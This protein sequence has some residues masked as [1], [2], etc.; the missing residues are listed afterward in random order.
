M[1]EFL[2]PKITQNPLKRYPFSLITTANG[3]AFVS[4]QGPLDLETGKV[5]GGDIKAQ[6]KL[7]LENIRKV[8][9]GAGLTMNHLVK[10]TVYITDINDFDAMSQAY[11]EHFPDHLPSRTTVGVATLWGGIKV[12]IEA[13]AV[14]DLNT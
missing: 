13:V 9:E 8:L 2:N 3:F 4:G 11:I 7:T 6:T 5:V 14:L 1:A 10:T 12:E